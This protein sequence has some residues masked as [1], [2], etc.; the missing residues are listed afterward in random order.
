MTSRLVLCGMAIGLML[1]SLC[2]SWMTA[3]VN[4]R[5][6]L[7]SPRTWRLPTTLVNSSWTM[8]TG[9]GTE[10]DLAGTRDLRSGQLVGALLHLENEGTWPWRAKTT[11][12]WEPWS[13]FPRQTG[14]S[15]CGSGFAHG[16]ASSGFLISDETRGQ[17]GRLTSSIVPLQGRWDS[18]PPLSPDGWGRHRQSTWRMKGPSCFS[19]QQWFSY[20]PQCVS[21]GFSSESSSS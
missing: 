13:L 17:T 15:R 14:S 12:V 1:H 5:S 7:S 6:F 11:G 18:S 9:R 3:S 21:P 16:S 20:C 2:D 19:D 4:G 8:S 10:R